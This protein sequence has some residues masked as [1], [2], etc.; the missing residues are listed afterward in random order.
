M[1]YYIF[2][3][4]AREYWKARFMGTTPNKSSAYLYSDKEL[5]VAFKCTSAT[6]HTRSS[7]TLPRE[8][9]GDSNYYLVTYGL[10]LIPESE[11]APVTPVPSGCVPDD[12]EI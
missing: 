1:R 4:A 7:P 2:H 11:V 9:E 3:E 10:K 5:M 12:E 8:F 6:W